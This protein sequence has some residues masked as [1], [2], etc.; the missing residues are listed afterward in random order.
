MALE[1]DSV[2]EYSEVALAPKKAFSIM[3]VSRYM[4]LEPPNM[5]VKLRSTGFV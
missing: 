3:I 5:T 1:L 2:S 4:N